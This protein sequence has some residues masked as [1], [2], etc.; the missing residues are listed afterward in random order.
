MM[1]LLLAVLLTAASSFAQS[2]GEIFVVNKSANSVSV[3]D[4][5]TLEVE[6]TIPVGSNPH[7][8]AMAPNGSKSYVGNAGSNTI[9]VIDLENYLETKQIASADFAFPHG[10]AFTP[11]S[12]RALVTSERNQKII[13][14]DAV[15][16]EILHVVDTDQ[17]GTHMTLVDGRGEWAYFTNR[18]SNTVSFMDLD[19]YEIVANVPVGRGGEGFALSPDGT[20]MWV[21]NRQEGTISVIDVGERAVVETISAG[22]SPNR[23]AFT[24]DGAHVLVGESG[25]LHV[26]DT[27]TRELVESVSVGSTLGMIASAPDSSRVYVTAGGD[28]RVYVVETES[29]TVTDAI[30]VGRGP[31]GLAVR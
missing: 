11:D 23:V 4:T 9:S 6:H 7:E 22:R 8:L 26:Y 21:A 29:W 24:A 15:N 13:V 3:V 12:Q 19:S 30:D 10:V 28:S 18:E 31:D 14:I 2:G 17:G 16:D 1:R 27:P 20:E 5:T 25:D